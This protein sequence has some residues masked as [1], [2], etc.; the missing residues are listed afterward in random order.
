[1]NFMHA[2]VPPPFL[3]FFFKPKWAPSLPLSPST[4]YSLFPNHDNVGVEN[5]LEWRGGG[6]RKGR[7]ERFLA[8]RGRN[9]EES[10]LDMKWEGEEGG[11]E[12]VEEGG[13][14]H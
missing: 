10:E 2:E 14:D 9:K 11:K 7:E 3:S 13:R 8:T 1:M 5:C 12:K 6:E 4:S